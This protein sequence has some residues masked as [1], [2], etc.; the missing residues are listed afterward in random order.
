MVESPEKGIG[1]LVAQEISSLIQ[2]ARRVEQVVAS[3]FTTSF[4]QQVLKRDAL[5]CQPP[6]Q[7]PSAQVQ[8]SR[9]IFYPRALTRE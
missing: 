6:L 4:L 9:E 5:L 8:L 7:C 3:Q 2:L 1:I